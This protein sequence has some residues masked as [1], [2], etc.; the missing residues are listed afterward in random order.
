MIVGPER[1][2][3]EYLGEKDATRG[4]PRLPSAFATERLLT[5]N[6]GGFP[7]GGHRLSSLYRTSKTALST[8]MKHYFP[9]S[10]SHK[11]SPGVRGWTTPVVLH[12]TR[13]HHA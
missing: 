8:L 2:E 5:G 9:A 6:R 7:F 4:A 11:Y 3:D 10:F 13:A 12:H 1:Q